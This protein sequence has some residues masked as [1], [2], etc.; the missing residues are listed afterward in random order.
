MVLGMEHRRERVAGE[1]RAELARQNKSKTDLAAHIGIST[2]TLRRRL[3]GV[4]PFFFEEIISTADFL[5][6]PVSTLLERS[7]DAA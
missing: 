3:D 7:E 5:G 6:V 1:I 4:R 2:D